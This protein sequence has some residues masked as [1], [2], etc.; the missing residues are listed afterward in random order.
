[1]SGVPED[2]FKAQMARLWALNNK[3]QVL[4]IGKL[5]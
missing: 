4:V 5:S 1:L 3:G 2:K